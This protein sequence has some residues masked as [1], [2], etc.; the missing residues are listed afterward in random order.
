LTQTDTSDTLGDM[1]AASVTAGDVF[2]QRGCLRHN[3]TSSLR[4]GGGL[5]LRREPAASSGSDSARRWSPDRSACYPDAERNRYTLNPSRRE[6]RTRTT[7]E[8]GAQGPDVGGCSTTILITLVTAL[9]VAAV[10]ALARWVNP[11][12]WLAG[13]HKMSAAWWTGCALIFLQSSV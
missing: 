13:P 6:N 7:N 8:A 9:I 10:V 4:L 2:N 3:G 5:W 12:A 11:P 1:G